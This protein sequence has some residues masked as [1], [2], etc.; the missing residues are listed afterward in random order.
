MLRC[1]ETGRHG[2]WLTAPNPEP[3]QAKPTHPLRCDLNGLTPPHTPSVSLDP[4]FSVATARAAVGVK[5][6]G[7]LGAAVRLTWKPLLG[8]LL[9]AVALGASID[10]FLP[11]SPSL[12][13]AIWTLQGR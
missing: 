13:H 11:D 2:A 9:C 4:W 8:A 7:W 1:A 3:S 10:T 5:G 12:P 6:Q